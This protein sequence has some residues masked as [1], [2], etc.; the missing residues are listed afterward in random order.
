MEAGCVIR[1]ARH[2]IV[3]GIIAATAW[4]LAAPTFAAAPASQNTSATQTPAAPKEGD[5]FVE[6]VKAFGQVATDI[7]KAVSFPIVILLLVLLSRDR[8]L[9]ALLDL[10]Q[11]IRERGGTL[12]ATVLKLQVGEVALDSLETRPVFFSRSPLGIEEDIIRERSSLIKDLEVVLDFP[13]TDT[14]AR[15]WALKTTVGQQA[16]KAML[17]ARQ[18]LIE[19]AAAATKP[20][21]L[22]IPL[23]TFARSLEAARFLEAARIVELLDTYRLLGATVDQI[24][25]AAVAS[26]DDRVVLHCMGVAYAKARQPEKANGVLEKLVWKDA[27]V[28]YPEAG[29]TWLA[30][31]Y[32]E[33]VNASQYDEIDSPKVFAAIEALLERGDR[34]RLTMNDA[35]WSPATP[36]NK[37]YHK[38]EVSKVIGSVAS[39]LGEV[40]RVPTQKDVYFK[41][42]L[43][44]LTECAGDIDG[45]SPT[46][47]D[48]NN[49]AD[50]YRQI[51]DHES[52]RHGEYGRAH[53]EMDKAF[54]IAT[55]PDPTFVNT[56]AFIFMRE[57]QPLKALMALWQYGENE[58]RGADEDDALQYIDN[59]IF[60]AKLAGA[61]SRDPRG[62][63]S[64]GA[65]PE[66]EVPYLALAA[67]ILEDARRFIERRWPVSGDTADDERTKVDDVLGFVYLQMPGHEQE[68]VAAYDRAAAAHDRLSR[69]HPARATPDAMWRRRVRR[70]G[71]LILLARSE[72]QRLAMDIAG[73]LRARAYEDL[74]KA[75]TQVEQFSLDTAVLPD[76]GARHARLRLD[77]VFALQALAEESFLQGAHVVARELLEVE[78]KI[79]LSIRA[80][81]TD[82]P[83]QRVL[84]DELT[85]DMTSRLRRS[86]AQRSFLGGRLEIPSDPSRLDTALIGKITESFSVARGVD[87]DLNCR[88]DLQLGDLLLTAAIA[89]K[90]GAAEMLCDRAIASL[91]LATTRN[92]PALRATTLRVL[93]D[94]Y[95]RRPAIVRHARGGGRPPSAKSG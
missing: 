22:R 41:R 61:V 58:A 42:A 72:R 73:Q 10:A 47:L 89:D 69:V 90:G 91:E 60:A 53:E 35:A 17:E 86:D 43:T 39:V 46:A 8:I 77:T 4:A 5:G 48:H 75:G 64:R 7:M 2:A 92:A 70:A 32:A 29:D 56:R 66:A 24:Q 93:A 55:G 50:L 51:G 12:D 54:A 31:A 21:D 14:V 49:L 87:D 26:A 15:S 1:I 18:K 25:A 84:G 88:I 20:E 28:Q 16:A 23:V 11:A 9:P 37:A 65:M 59:Q 71:A 67:A 44:A 83:L 81:L 63:A 80:A 19:A 78:G 95:A 13:V 82:G 57:Q 76:H 94:A 45:E 34:I 79:A 74:A 68:A 6:G 36:S 40:S 33:R 38:R 27:T 52:N 62:A 85:V 30:A 3:V